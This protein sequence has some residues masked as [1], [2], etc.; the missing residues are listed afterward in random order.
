[1]GDRSGNSQ[2][3]MV[4]RQR[5]EETSMTGGRF[6]QRRATLLL[7]LLLAGTVAFLAACTPSVP[8]VVD[9]DPPSQPTTPAPAPEPVWPPTVTLEPVHTGF[10][11]PVLAVGAGDGTE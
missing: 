4:R 8:R 1:R 6:S 5:A 10:E 2:L 9:G 3:S 11:Q 7:G